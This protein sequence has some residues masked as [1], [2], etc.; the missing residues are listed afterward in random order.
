ML[1]SSV[2]LVGLKATHADTP[3][4]SLQQHITQMQQE[5]KDEP[6]PVFQWRSS[7]TSS[8]G[9]SNRPSSEYDTPIGTCVR[10]AAVQAAAPAPA[11]QPLAS[12]SR[13]KSTTECQCTGVSC[14][15]HNLRC[16]VRNGDALCIHASVEQPCT[17][18]PLRLQLQPSGALLEGDSPADAARRLLTGNRALHSPCNSRGSSTGAPCRSGCGPMHLQPTYAI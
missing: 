14:C 13:R 2:L 8:T 18:T 3:R 17:S 5:M 6:L 9:Y 10:A 15:C 1:P 12:C 16:A 11:D 7:C 4:F